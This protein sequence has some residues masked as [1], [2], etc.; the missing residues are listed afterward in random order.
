MLRQI[1]IFLLVP[2]LIIPGMIPDDLSFT[3]LSFVPAQISSDDN[4]E[5]DRSIACTARV[6]VV[7]IILLIS[8]LML[9]PNL[10]PQQ[11]LPIIRLRG[12]APPFSR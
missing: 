10:I 3:V 9:S 5:P 4:F 12:R 11:E 2:I 7:Q 6:I 8:F 1:A